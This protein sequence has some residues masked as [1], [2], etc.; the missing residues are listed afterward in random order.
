MAEPE[1]HTCPS[2]E[3][4]G[5][6]YKDGLRSC[7]DGSAV[8]RWLC[9]G[10]GYRFSLGHNNS[11]AVQG[12]RGNSQVCVFL[13]EA[14]N[15]TAVKETQTLAGE[16]SDRILLFAWQSK[17]KGLCDNTIKV[18]VIRLN[19]LRRMGANL[20]DPSNIEAVF[21]LE[22]WTPAKKWQYVQTYAAYTKTMGIPWTK[23]KVQYEP[24]QQ[25][26]PTRSEVE[27]LIGGLGTRTATFV[28]ALAD[29]GARCGEMCQL[30]WSEV[31]A[32]NLRI[33]I[34][35]PEKGSKSRVITVSE[36]T[37]AMI[38]KLTRK[39]EPYVFNPRSRSIESTFSRQRNRLTIKL[40]MPN[41]RKIHLHSM[42]RFYAD[43]L[44]KKSRFNT[45]KVQAKLGHKRLS[46]TEKYFGDFDAEGCTYETARAYT[47]ED[48]E[49]LRQQG[50]EQY[51]EGNDET[52]KPVK[53]YSR[54]T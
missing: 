46:S 12:I 10:C 32:D 30:E 25:Y 24:K 7:S 22:N 18:R 51:G 6:F 21:A 1:P 31:D 29:T 17:K 23:I 27:T 49:Q 19:V 34:N 13:Q 41:I 11:K 14:K 44:Y 35:K 20:D 37:I 36:R 45:R 2:C 38:M 48:Q 9:R 50:Y 5:P 40:Q 54:L 47:I 53:L 4:K 16:I 26:T 39:Y 33:P 15:L 28:Q 43:Q 3:G 42:R 52:G 8:Q